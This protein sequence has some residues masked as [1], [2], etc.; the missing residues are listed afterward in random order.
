MRGKKRLL[1]GF[2]LLL[3]LCLLVLAQGC[4]TSHYPHY[5][6][7]SDPPPLDEESTKPANMADVL[8]FLVP[9][10]APLVACCH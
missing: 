8:G 9:I 10:L 1:P 4:A 5:M 6:A 2:H 3:L 7:K